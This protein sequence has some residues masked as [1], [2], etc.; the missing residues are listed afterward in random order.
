MVC[1]VIGG[2][3]KFSKRR[4]RW[5]E[6]S[7]GSR[8]R[9]LGDGEKKTGWKNA[10]KSYFSSFSSF[11]NLRRLTVGWFGAEERKIGAKKC[12]K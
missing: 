1:Q 9:G 5:D 12:E 8:F 7:N 3:R 11:P 10:E 6:F 4:R 2:K